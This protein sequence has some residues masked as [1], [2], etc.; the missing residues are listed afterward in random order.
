MFG[1]EVESKTWLQDA[2]WDDEFFKK[3]NAPIG[4]DK[5]HMN[6]NY[7]QS[8]KDY[9]KRID[10]WRAD[11]DA[12]DK[13]KDRW[14]TAGDFTGVSGTMFKVGEI[15]SRY[16][17]RAY[18]TKFGFNKIDGKIPGVKS[19]EIMSRYGKISAVRAASSLK[20]LGNTFGVIGAVATVGESLADG[21]LTLGD[22]AKVAFSVVTMLP[23]G[24]ILGVADLS[25]KW[26]TGKGIA[27]RIAETI[28]N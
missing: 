6:I 26:S 20:I 1:T 9:Y 5:G 23:G 2:I 22:G 25:L 19:A 13:V 27:D 3:D 14:G 12:F 16:E 4:N 17:S 21:K 7:S 28:D 15:A 18:S 11:R 10:I 8:V 24:W